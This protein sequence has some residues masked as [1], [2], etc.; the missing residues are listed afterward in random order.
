MNQSLDRNE[1]H[2]TPLRAVQQFI[3]LGPGSNGDEP[4]P[5]AFADPAWIGHV[6]AVAGFVDVTITSVETKVPVGDDLDDAI[7]FFE[8]D[9]RTSL[10]SFTDDDTIDRISVA[11]RDDL[12]QHV[13]DQGVVLP[14][15]AWLV[16]ARTPARGCAR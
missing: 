8:M 5:F 13:S 12:A 15:A 11:L 14:A 3:G 4:G 2:A 10:R 1:W 6:L 9:A 7:R 16:V